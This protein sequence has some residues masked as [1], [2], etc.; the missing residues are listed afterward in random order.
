MNINCFKKTSKSSKNKVVNTNK[1][2]HGKT[3]VSYAQKLFNG[4]DLIMDDEKYFN[5]TANNVVRNRFF[6]STDSATAPS[7]VKV[8][9]KTQFEPRV[10]IRMA[11]YSKGTSD[12]C[13]HKS[14]QIVNQETYLKEFI[15]KRLLS[16]I[17]FEWKLVVLTWSDQSTLFKYCS[18][19]FDWKNLPF[20]LVLTIHQ[21]FLK[22]V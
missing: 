8:E 12:I 6:Y 5:S 11:M 1:F 7:K 16:E 14:K 21:M 2:E 4:C 3:A 17:S 13:V 18:R 15:G 22:L 20:V 9:C 10:M 19:T